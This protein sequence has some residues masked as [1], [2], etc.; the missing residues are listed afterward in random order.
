MSVSNA[1]GESDELRLAVIVL[2]PKAEVDKLTAR[3]QAEQ[4]ALQAKARAARARWEKEQ[5]ELACRE[6][7]QR[8]RHDPDADRLNQLEKRVRRLE[9][10][11]D[12]VLQK[13]DRLE[14]PKPGEKKPEQPPPKQP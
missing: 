6:S 12:A 14:N 4:A 2:A 5:A 9:A 11:I 8:L 1:A 13:L 3:Q 10:S 7:R